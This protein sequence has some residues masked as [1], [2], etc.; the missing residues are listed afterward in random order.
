[1][2]KLKIG[3][4]GNHTEIQKMLNDPRVKKSLNRP[5]FSKMDLVFEFDIWEKSCD[6]FGNQFTPSKKKFYSENNNIPSIKNLKNIKS[7]FK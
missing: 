2:K 4:T 1:M 6:F 5:C 3:K 7:K